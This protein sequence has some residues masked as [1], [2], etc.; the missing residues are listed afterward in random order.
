[1]RSEYR[2]F[3]YILSNASRTVFYVGVSNSLI[4]RVGQHRNNECEFTAKY[5]C[6]DLV[7][8]EEYSCIEV[9]IKREKCV[10]RWHRQ[11]KIDLIKSVNPEMKDLYD[12]VVRIFNSV[13]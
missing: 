5:G 3:I 8:Y 13:D 9:A 7:Y 11:W 10:K 2:F 1:M 12:R 6:Y 4:R